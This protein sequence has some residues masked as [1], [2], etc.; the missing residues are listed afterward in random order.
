MIRMTRHS[1]MNRSDKSIA[2]VQCDSDGRE[3]EKLRD[4]TR[5]CSKTMTRPD[6]QGVI[7][8]RCDWTCYVLNARTSESSREVTVEALRLVN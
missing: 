4:E 2:N 8:L 5:I 6:R 3:K 1:K 7:A